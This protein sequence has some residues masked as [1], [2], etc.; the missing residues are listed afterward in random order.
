MTEIVCLG[1]LCFKGLYCTS[2]SRPLVKYGESELR[3]L[4]HLS[5]LTKDIPSAK[6]PERSAIVSCTSFKI[7]MFTVA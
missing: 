7:M 4:F 5:S 2:F 6:G 1:E 3:I